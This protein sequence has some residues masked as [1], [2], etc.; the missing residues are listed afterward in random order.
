MLFVPLTVGLHRAALAAGTGQPTWWASVAVAVTALCGF[1]A[2]TPAT[3]WLKSPAGRRRRFLTPLLTYGGATVVAGVGALLLTGPALPWWALPYALLLG[4]AGWLIANG[5]ERSLTSGLLTTAAASGLVLVTAHPDPTPV[6][7]GRAGVEVGLAV[8]AWAYFAGTVFS[9]KALIRERRNDR[10]RQVS[11]GYHVAITLASL[12]L[13]I[14]G[15][16]AWPWSMFFAAT[17]A[18]AVVLPA[19]QSRGRR[20]TPALIGVVE[21]VFSLV[22]LLLSLALPPAA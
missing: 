14:R 7:A 3:G 22:L 16:L 13:M 6:V 4:V 10:F 15:Q 1:F 21:I 18:R 5:R 9:V 8:L 12:I 20:L 11:I 2:F 17:T 19:L